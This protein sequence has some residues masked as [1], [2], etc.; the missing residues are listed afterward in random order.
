[1][2]QCFFLN[3]VQFTSRWYLRVGESLYAFFVISDVSPVLP[4]KQSYSVGVT[5]D[6]FFLVLSMLIVDFFLFL[7][8]FNTRFR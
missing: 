2:L 6:V 3:L 8:L 5:G 1:M 4:L 7:K